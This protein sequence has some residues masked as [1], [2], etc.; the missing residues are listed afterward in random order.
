MFELAASYRTL[1]ISLRLP[2][3]ALTDAGTIAA[4]GPEQIPELV[5]FLRAQGAR[6]QLAPVWTEDRVRRAGAQGL[7][8]RH[9]RLARRGG[10]IA[11]VIG[12]WDQSAYKQAVVRGYSGWLKMASRL[13]RLI[14]PRIGEHVRTA[15]ASMVCV[16]GDD[17]A[18]FRPLLREA[19]RLAA[20][21]RFDYLVVG[22]DAGDPLLP[23]ARA[24]PH[25]EYPSRL[26]VVS[27]AKGGDLDEPLDG[28]PAY[29][30]VATL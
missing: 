9:V 22:L 27:W 18:V 12:L 30:D 11:G 21:M 1:A 5:A 20:A 28:R 14:V 16:A 19:Y 3:R 2:R 26:Y 13:G 6:R 10:A 17:P 15:Y 23:V 29:V 8:I 24:Y 4:A 25:V 7:D